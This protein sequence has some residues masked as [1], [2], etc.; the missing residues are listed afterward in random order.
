MK[1]TRTC[2]YRPASNGQIERV[3]RTVEAMLSAFVSEHQRDW[4]T[5]LPEIMMA[6]RSSV[7]CSTGQTPNAM[8]LGREVELPIDLMV[9]QPLGEPAPEKCLYVIELREK[10]RL[11][12]ENA[13]ETL[14]RLAVT[15][16]RN[17]ERKL[18]T[19][20]YE[21][22]TMVWV[23]IPNRKTGRSAKLQSHWQGP[24]RVVDKINDVT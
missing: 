14:G 24:C 5:V 4:D 16:K 23:Y 7:H 3:N 8:M 13:R 1:K 9:G 12:H 10:L 15:Q 22:G 17:Y 2:P 18:S 6:Y 19:Y 20:D 11:A 21:P